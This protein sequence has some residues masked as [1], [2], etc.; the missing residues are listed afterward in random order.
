VAARSAV[1]E[2]GE[3]NAVGILYSGEGKGI[4]LRQRQLQNLIEL[5]RERGER[6]PCLLVSLDLGVGTDDRTVVGSTNQLTSCSIDQV[7]PKA[8][9]TNCKAST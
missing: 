5:G 6:R 8:T 7:V 3:E 4:R 2:A 1:G 9:K